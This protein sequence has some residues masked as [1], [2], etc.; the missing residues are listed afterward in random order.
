MPGWID[1]VV[2]GGIR[3][4]MRAAHANYGVDPVAFLVIYVAS[5]PFFYYSIFRMLRALA[6]KLPNEVMIWSTIFLAS[7]SAPFLYVLFFGRNLPWWV[8]GVIALLIGQGIFS[9][10]RCLTKKRADSPGRRRYRQENLTVNGELSMP[11]VGLEPTR[12]LPLT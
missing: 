1:H 7:M 9:L 10:I 12:E 5:G 8:Y 6:R 4:L 3:E 11:A 2:L